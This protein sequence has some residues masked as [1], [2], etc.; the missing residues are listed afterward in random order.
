MTDF[1]II[2]VTLNSA[3]TISDTMRSVV[4]QKGVSVQ[5]I[6]KDAG[7]TDETTSIAA[8]VNP[9]AVIKVSPDLGVYDGM[10]QG[11]EFATGELI[12]FLN[13]D[14]Y[15][16]DDGVL[17]AVRDKFAATSC[18]VLYGN[19][20]I[21]NAKGKL[22]RRWAGGAVSSGNLRGRQLPH[23]ALFVRRS[24]LAR[25]CPPF[26]PTYRISADYKQQLLLVEKFSL[27]VEYLARTIAIMRTGGESTRNLRAVIRGWLECTRAYREVHNR[28]GVWI[29]VR[30]V[31]S[32]IRQL[33][34]GRFFPA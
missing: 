6:L 4:Q 12:G 18:D 7:S 15:Y 33:S 8:R 34:V 17:E 23:P 25:L 21:V 14:D 20:A 9:K 31:T 5:H 13:S 30:K 22:V 3:S 19:I 28:T 27:H 26:D 32:K 2:T 11:F 10:N 24:A 1:S 16:A 29:V